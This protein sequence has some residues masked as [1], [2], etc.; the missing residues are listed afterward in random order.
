MSYQ[1]AKGRQST[2][3]LV[4]FTRAEK[5]PICRTGCERTSPGFNFNSGE[6]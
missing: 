6:A 1:R 2:M 4:L 3:F 5:L